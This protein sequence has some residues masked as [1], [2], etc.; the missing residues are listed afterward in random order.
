MQLQLINQH[1][2]HKLLTSNYSDM[3]SGLRRISYK[4][5]ARVNWIY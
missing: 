3:A 2:E 1:S 5:H 4:P